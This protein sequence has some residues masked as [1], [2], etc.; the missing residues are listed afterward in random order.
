M[1]V[2]GRVKEQRDTNASSDDRFRDA[3]CVSF[4]EFIARGL[5]HGRRQVAQLAAHPLLHF[6]CSGHGLRHSRYRIP[7]IALDPY[8][9]FRSSA[10]G[11]SGE[12]E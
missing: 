12:Y 4:G 9:R 8:R 11:A 6:H 10:G 2:E 5:R 3:V 1:G 7:A